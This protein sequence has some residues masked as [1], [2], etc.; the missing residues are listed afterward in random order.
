M[1][2][3]TLELGANGTHT[4]KKKRLQKVKGKDKALQES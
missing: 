2:D 4:G 3:G 1:S